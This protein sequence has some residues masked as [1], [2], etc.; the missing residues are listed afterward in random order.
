ME[1]NLP[2]G[3]SKE[4][5]NGSNGLDLAKAIGAGLAKSAVA[6][7][8]DGEQ[9]DLLDVLPENYC[10]ILLFRLVQ[11]GHHR[12]CCEKNVDS[13]SILENAFCQTILLIKEY[14]LTLT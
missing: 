8:V 5:E 2:D 11:T 6:V 3:S 13:V 10:G 1:I 12:S 14:L 9:R 4:L 7:T